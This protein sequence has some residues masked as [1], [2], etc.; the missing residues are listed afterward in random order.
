MIILFAWNLMNDRSLS[1]KMA[2]T[3]DAFVV[4]LPK[5]ASLLGIGIAITSFAIDLLSTQYVVIVSLTAMFI[6]F[7][8]SYLLV[9]FSA[10]V[11]PI[12]L[13]SLLSYCSASLLY[14]NSPILL[15]CPGNIFCDWFLSRLQNGLWFCAKLVLS[16]SISKGGVGEW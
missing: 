2:E 14:P 7:P 13:S 4:P 15:N 11:P 10:S 6:V 8:L 5:T 16:H 12:I 3:V 9:V 1:N